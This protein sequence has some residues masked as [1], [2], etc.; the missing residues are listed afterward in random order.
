MN[1]YQAL[2]FT[3]LVLVVIAV[4]QGVRSVVEQRGVRTPFVAAAFAAL[5]LYAADRL[6]PVGLSMRDVPAAVAAL[7]TEI[8][9]IVS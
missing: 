8:L 7:L 2:L 6:S 1:A 5:V 4:V 9:R 3:G